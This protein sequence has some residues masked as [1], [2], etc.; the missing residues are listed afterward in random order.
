MHIY[1]YSSIPEDYLEDDLDLYNFQR[2]NKCVASAVSGEENALPTHLKVKSFPCFRVQGKKTKSWGFSVN[3]SSVDSSV[4]AAWW[5]PARCALSLSN[6]HETHLMHNH[7]PSYSSLRTPGDATK[8]TDWVAP[9][10][11]ALHQ[12]HQRT[13]LN[14]ASKVVL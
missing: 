13:E 12:R 5:V 4:S 8:L 11:A 1:I 2:Q 14:G 10:T 9:A 6:R 3:D 7:V